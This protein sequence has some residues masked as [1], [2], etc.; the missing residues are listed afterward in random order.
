MSL[1]RYL[2][3]KDGLL[4]P[5]GTLSLSIP[6][7]A[8]AQTNKEV[9]RATSSEKQKRGPFKKYSACLRAEIGKYASHHGVAAASRHFSRKL[10]K[11]VNEM[12]VRSIRS[13]YQEGVKRKRPVEVDEEED[14]VALPPIKRGRPVLLGQELDSLVQMYL[15][16]MRDAVSARIVIAAARG[17]LLK[18]NRS[19][20]VEFGGHVQLNR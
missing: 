14:V 20:L 2:K 11:G 12:T 4:D 8:I 10:S 1:S 19:K 5:R 13:A 3:P 7:A 6:A 15:G 18:C 17:I 9:Q 16:N